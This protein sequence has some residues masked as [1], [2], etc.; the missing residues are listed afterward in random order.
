VEVEGVEVRDQGPSVRLR[1]GFLP[2]RVLAFGW[3][4]VA[5]HL[6]FLAAAHP[7]WDADYAAALRQRLI[8]PADTKVANLSKGMAVKLSFLTAE[9]FRPPILLLDEPT[10]GVDPVMRREIVDLIVEAVPADS[11]RAVV[12]SSHIL[13]DV[14]AVAERVVLIRQGRLIADTSVEALRSEGPR[15]SV[16]DALYARL[17]SHE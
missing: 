14:E 13:E 9:A 5:E 8:L 3:M 10:S 15:G 7:G 11:P 6:E 2:E 4:T 1:V 12:F 16:S 17:T